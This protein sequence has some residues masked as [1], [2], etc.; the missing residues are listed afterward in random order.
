MRLTTYTD[1]ALRTLLHVGTNQGRL[2]TVEEIATLHAIS[3]NHIMKVVHQLGMF[4]VV[5]TVR[6]RSGRLRL[7]QPAGTINIGAVVRFTES[8]FYMAACFDPDGVPCGLHGACGLKHVPID[9]TAACL[10]VLDATTLADLLPEPV[11][12]H[13]V[14]RFHPPPQ[15]IE[16]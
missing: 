12:A 5:E 6:G 13:A 4:G 15:K 7:A 11:P 10:A 9:A 14:R 3:K 2:V 16:H 8:D 1:Y